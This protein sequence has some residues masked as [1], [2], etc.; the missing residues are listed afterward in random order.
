MVIRRSDGCH[1]GVRAPV[2]QKGSGIML[3]AMN[4]IRS[5]SAWCIRLV[6]LVV[7]CCVALPV[8]A[9]S[10]DEIA[11]SSYI[12][13]AKEGQLKKGRDGT[14]VL[15]LPKSKIDNEVYRLH[16]K[17]GMPFNSKPK[18]VNRSDWLASVASKQR[19]G[20][21]SEWYVVVGS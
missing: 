13:S 5:I 21:K 11:K 16:S 19:R 17:F 1:R 3:L 4:C 7:V 14:W 10:D 18:K 12:V 2:V 8:Y 9:L 20:G 15:A 6:V